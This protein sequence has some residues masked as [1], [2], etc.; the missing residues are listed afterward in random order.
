[1]ELCVDRLLCVFVFARLDVPC[2]VVVRSRRGLTSFVV[3]LFVR[4]RA[5]ARYPASIGRRRP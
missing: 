5:R 4:R 1:M 2:V 3:V